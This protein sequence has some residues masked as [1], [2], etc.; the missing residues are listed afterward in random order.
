MGSNIAIIII[1]PIALICKNAL[2]SEYHKGE[3]CWR[4]IASLIDSREPNNVQPLA[5]VKAT[6]GAI[7]CE[8]SVAR[9]DKV[10]P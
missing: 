6:L 9:I 2:F 5:Y 7:I 4:C 8:H 1:R 3:R 10:V